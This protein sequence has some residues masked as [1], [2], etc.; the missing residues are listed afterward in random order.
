MSAY[1]QPIPHI[2]ALVRLALEGPSGVPVNPNTSWHPPYFAGGRL[3][4][5]RADELGQALL[6]ENVRSVN[7]RYS[8]RSPVGEPYEYHGGRRLTVPEAIMAIRGYEYQACER[9]DFDRSEV[10][11]FLHRLLSSV[12]TRVVGVQEADTWSIVSDG[13]DDIGL[14]YRAGLERARAARAG[15]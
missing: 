3:D 12:A 9:P 8:Q 13:A 14:V 10:H 1:V 7:Y 15:V 2:N 4:H 5:T 11:A 6:R